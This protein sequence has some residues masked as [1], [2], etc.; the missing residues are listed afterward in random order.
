MTSTPSHYH[1]ITMTSPLGG[2]LLGHAEGHLLAEL[3]SD[4]GGEDEGL[5]LA[6]AHGLEVGRSP[7]HQSVQP[8]RGG[9]GFDVI[10]PESTEFSCRLLIS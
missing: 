3:V 5:V 9:A 4:G 6:G 10:G 1:D 8:T 7:A 2:V